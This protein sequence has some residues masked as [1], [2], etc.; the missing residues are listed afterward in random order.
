MPTQIEVKNLHLSH[1]KGE[2]I[3]VTHIEH[4]HG[5]HSDPIVSIGTSYHGKKNEAMIEIPYENVDDVILAL[6]ESK[7]VCSSILH[8]EFHAEL[9]SDSGGG[10]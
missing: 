8:E 9:D 2:T 6:V 10:Q 4:P 7:K 1:K 5:E 3:T